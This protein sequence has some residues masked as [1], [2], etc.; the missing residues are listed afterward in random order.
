MS[1]DL[2][3]WT[4]IKELQQNRDYWERRALDAMAATEYYREQ[5]SAAHELLGRVIHQT[6]ERWGSVNL[7]RHFPTD[8]LHH[9]RTH[10]NPSGMD[11]STHANLERTI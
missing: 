10:T 7:S 2:H 5:L 6:S 8:N 3:P 1:D 9:K 11:A 4:S